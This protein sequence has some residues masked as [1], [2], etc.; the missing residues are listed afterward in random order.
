MLLNYVIGSMFSGKSTSC[1]N[2]VLSSTRN[3]KIIVSPSLKG[4]G[5]LSRN[6]KLED[7]PKDVKIFNTL[8]KKCLKTL[9]KLDDS[10]IFIDEVQFMNKFYLKKLFSKHELDPKKFDI[11]VAGLEVGQHGVNFDLYHYL[12]DIFQD[13]VMNLYAPCAMCTSKKGLVAV[14]KWLHASHITDEYSVLCNKCF[15]KFFTY[16]R[17][18]LPVPSPNEL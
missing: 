1:I 12:V 18:D 11:L 14:R 3:H 17:T 10:I 15:N 4:R 9:S 8:D 5:W 16:G 13:K 7:L 6:H 2:R